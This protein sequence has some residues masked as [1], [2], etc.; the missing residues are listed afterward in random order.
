[1]SVRYGKQGTGQLCV[2]VVLDNGKIRVV[3]DTN[4][5]TP[6]ERI[7]SKRRRYNVPEKQHNK[8][9]IYVKQVPTSEVLIC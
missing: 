9:N 4:S 1:M 3:A 7:S 5:G 8:T 6:A 2:Q